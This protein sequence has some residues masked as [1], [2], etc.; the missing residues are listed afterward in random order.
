MITRQI[1]VIL[2]LILL[3][4]SGCGDSNP[5]GRQPVS[6]T[7]TLNGQP[8]ERGT[9]EFSPKESGTASGASIQDGAYAIPADKG[10]PPGEY[11]VRIS[12]ADEEAEPMEMPG[13]SSKISPE[14]IPPE[15]N[16]ESEQ[17]FTVSADGENEFSLDIETSSSN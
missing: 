7:I 10:L 5:L 16:A 14:L 17:T 8:L 12:A 9:I 3:L 4:A 13:E 1:P 11:L 15:Y 6:G 2:S